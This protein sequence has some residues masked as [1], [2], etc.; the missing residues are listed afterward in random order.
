MK[1]FLYFF[2]PK[3]FIFGNHNEIFFLLLFPFHTFW[4]Q[5]KCFTKK[6]NIFLIDKKKQN[7]KFEYI[8]SERL[9]QLEISS[10]VF[11]MLYLLLK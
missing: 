8:R 10:N 5:K 2:I 6:Y 4:Q 9:V 11:C 3:T 1:F 7:K